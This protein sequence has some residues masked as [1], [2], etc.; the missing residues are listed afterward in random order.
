MGTAGPALYGLCEAE[1][2]PNLDA[3]DL[4]EIAGGICI[5]CSCHSNIKTNKIH[6]DLALEKCF[7]SALQRD[8][9]SGGTV[10]IYTLTMDYIFMKEV[11]SS[12]V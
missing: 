5:Y 3:E 11:P 2:V 4:F 9:M 7:K 8:V 12:D 10:R 6:F 1:Y